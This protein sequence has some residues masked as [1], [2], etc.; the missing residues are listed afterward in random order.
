MEISAMTLLDYKE[1][2][3]SCSCFSRV[4]VEEFVARLDNIW[5]CCRLDSAI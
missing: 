3:F 1:Y 2:T 4:V 5:P